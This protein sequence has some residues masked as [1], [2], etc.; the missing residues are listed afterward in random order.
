MTTPPTPDSPLIGGPIPHDRLQQAAIDRLN[1]HL[2]HMS[3]DD[4]Q[5]ARWAIEQAREPEEVRAALLEATGET[6]RL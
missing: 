1:N 2:A 5:M 3:L 6:I 4:Y